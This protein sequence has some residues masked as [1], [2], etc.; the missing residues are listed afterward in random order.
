[1]A[2]DLPAWVE[3]KADEWLTIDEFGSRLGVGRQAANRYAADYFQD[4]TQRFRRGRGRPGLYIQ[5]SAVE[6]FLEDWLT[7]DE[8]ARR[9]KTSRK[10]AYRVAQRFDWPCVKTRPRRYQRTAVEATEWPIRAR[11]RRRGRWVGE[12]FTNLAATDELPDLTDPAVRETWLTVPEARDLIGLADD[13]RVG[14]QSL[15]EAWRFVRLKRQLYYF[16]DD[17]VTG[18]GRRT[19]DGHVR[20]KDAPQLTGRS[21]ATLSNMVRAG[22]LP[23]VK[24]GGQRWL[25]QAALENLKR[26]EKMG[27]ARLS[28]PR[29][30]VVAAYQAHGQMLADRP[31][32][33]IRLRYGLS[34]GDVRTLAE[35]GE[36]LGLTR[37]RVNQ[38]E[39]DA[40]IQLG[41]RTPDPFGT[42]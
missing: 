9:L 8:I 37:A 36:T 14:Q 35:V 25:E 6:H 21:A 18:R 2:D 19:V 22:K 34:D 13:I 15:K 7:L 4:A 17:V 32:E 5:R 24:I 20:L 23:S 42:S 33:I 11:S 41:L 12:I 30:Q 27:R 31:A 40:L 28:L 10:M 3:V 39:R 29:E 26:L 16:R 1:M 38:L